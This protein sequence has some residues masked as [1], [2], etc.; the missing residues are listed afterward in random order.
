M[1]LNEKE[2][3]TQQELCGYSKKKIILEKSGREGATEG[4]VKNEERNRRPARQTV[5]TTLN[6]CRGCRKEKS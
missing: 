5:F 1:D 6:C 3:T 2:A 4:T